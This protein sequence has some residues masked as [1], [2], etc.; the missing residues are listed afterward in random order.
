MSPS[1]PCRGR[2]AALTR[3]AAALPVL[4]VLAQLLL[5]AV[6]AAYAG[7]LDE[8]P[9]ES[10]VQKLQQSPYS[11]TMHS[12]TENTRSN[13]SQ[14]CIQLHTSNTCSPWGRRCCNT[15]INKIKFLPGT[16]GSWV[17]WT[18]PMHPAIA[19]QC[20]CSCPHV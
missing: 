18:G 1:A 15:H 17:G 5:A 11:A 13:T 6:P 8:F 3:A 16:W 20:N 9:F 7:V 19:V 2:P 10:C 4:L 14:F 12:Y